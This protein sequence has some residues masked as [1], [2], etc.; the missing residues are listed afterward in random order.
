MNLLQII[1]K[2]CQ[3]SGIVQPTNVIGSNITQIQQMLG[4]LEEEINELTSRHAW[5]ALINEVTWT[6]IANENQGDIKTICPGYRFIRNSTLWDNTTSLPIIGPL[7]GIVW[8][9][10]KATQ[11]EGP[12]WTW[13]LRNDDL[14]IIPTPTAGLTWKFEYVSSFGIV[15]ADGLTRKEFFTSDTDLMVL[16]SSLH[17]SGLRWRWRADKGIDYAE[18]YNQYELL[19]KDAMARD[20]GASVLYSDEEN[21]D[22]GPGI[23]IPVMSWL[24]P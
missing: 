5:N 20:G 4:L 17:L 12:H 6:T 11:D 7:T 10:R 16:P 19:V 15:S 22:A 1:Q 21:I 14:L 3:R 18:L 8:Q 13:R 23:F 9:Q 2:A 24:Q